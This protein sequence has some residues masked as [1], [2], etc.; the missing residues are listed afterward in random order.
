MRELEPKFESKRL[1]VRLWSGFKAVRK[2][3][4]MKHFRESLGDT[5]TTLLL[6][7]MPQL[8]ATYFYFFIVL[9]TNKLGSQLSPAYVNVSRSIMPSGA[10]ASLF[11]VMG[12]APDLPSDYDT[13]DTPMKPTPISP[14]VGHTD[15]RKLSKN[16]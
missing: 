8:Y 1:S 15:W 12:K 4:K 7:L 16:D 11:D 9:S 14:P 6:T 2:K 5:K 13:M 10:A 3:Q